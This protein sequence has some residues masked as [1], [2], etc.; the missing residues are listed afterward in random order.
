PAFESFHE[1]A[2]GTFGLHCLFLIESQLT[3]NYAVTGRTVRCSFSNTALLFYS[4][5]P[6]RSTAT[7]PANATIQQFFLISAR[8]QAK[9]R[10]RGFSAEAPGFYLPGPLPRTTIGQFA[11]KPCTE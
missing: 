9:I 3:G 6:A 5:R 1:R 10:A 4:G 8:C 11:R 2:V 7:G